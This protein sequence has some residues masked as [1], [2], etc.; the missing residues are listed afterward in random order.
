MWKIK[1][2]K[3]KARKTLKR[4]IWTLMILGLFMTSI[5]GEYLVNKDGYS[6]IKIIYEYIQNKGEQQLSPQEILIN[7]YADK[8]I[9]QVFTGDMTKTINY[10]NEKH[11][12]TKGVIFSIFNIYTKGQAQVQNIFNSIANYKDKEAMASIILII[13]SIGGML[14]RV[15]ISY[16]LKVG[17][18]RI[19]LESI[20]YKKT[21]IKRLKYAF[22]K[23]RYLPTVKTIFLA[24]IYKM[25]WNLTIVGGII[26]NYSY[27]MVQYIVA[28]NPSIK[29]KDAIKMSGEMMNGSKWQAFKL[30]MSFL[31]WNILQYATLGLAGLYV[32]PYYAA[33]IAE[34]YK[35][36]RE[37]YIKGQ[38][39]NFEALNDEKLFEENELEKYPDSDEILRKKIKIDYNKKYEPT[40]IILFFFI[41]SFVGWLWEVGLYLF[42]DGILVNRGTMYGPW[43]PIY[44]V[45]CTLIVLLT[46]FKTFRKMLKNPLLTF[47]VVMA[48]CT[49]I[50]YFTS[51]YIEKVS[52]IMYWDYTGVFM[53]IKGRVCFECSMFFGIGGCLC[54]YF[55]APFL[56]RRLQRF[57]TKFKVT[58]CTLLALLFCSDSIYSQFYP[59]TGEGITSQVPNRVE[60][61]KNGNNVIE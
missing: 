38:K 11:N 57:T 24:E 51:W 22:K 59:H 16:P 8:A 50:E 18:K 23:E 53:N 3:E 17:E 60:E 28:E 37:K 31:G 9:S 20:N 42:R 48:L 25:L 27:K 15:F 44:G 1:E 34:L 6:N 30:D 33:T 19:Y 2:I 36:L 14:I 54:V 40:S 52:G 13:A 41:F 7:E 29:A 43:L 49:I 47:G 12:I 55:V 35:V 45:G 21:R 56:E 5:V 46:K 39:Y 10:Y 58:V 26:K 32:T 4:N 61:N